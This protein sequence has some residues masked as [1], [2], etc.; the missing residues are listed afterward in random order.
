MR[1]RTV[2][3][4][5][6]HIFV[7]LVCLSIFFFPATVLAT[8]ASITVSGNEEP[9]PVH[10]SASFS[11]YEHCDNATPQHCWTVDTGSL[12][13]YLDNGYLGGDSGHGSASWTI[14]LDGGSLAQGEHIVKAV[15]TDSEGVVNTK[16]AT[17]TIDNTPEVT[18]SMP[19]PVEGGI[20]VVGSVQFKERVYGKEGTI[21]LYINGGY[22]GSKSYEGKSIRVSWED[23]TGKLLDAGS[24]P[25]GENTLKIRAV[26][27]NGA[28]TIKEQKFTVDYAPKLTEI[29]RS[30]LHDDEQN[31]DLFD[32]STTVTFKEYVGGNE[33]TVQI[34][35]NGSYQGART[36]EGKSH[37]VKYSEITGHLLNVTDWLTNEGTVTF[38]A[39]A[40]NGAWATKTWRIA[41]R[42]EN[43]GPPPNSCP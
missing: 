31:E 24:L 36:Y 4:L 34:F 7:F 8:S 41:G 18:T 14:T 29:I 10:A 11:S 26:A 16:T 5:S 22:W 28:T 6:P 19:S 27:S 39:I 17:I 33:G 12:A 2:Q 23:I 20:D 43:L 25:N 21:F 32:L 37:T 38:K 1:S 13:V 15:A 35:V 3:L 42:D 40:H 30:D 9:I